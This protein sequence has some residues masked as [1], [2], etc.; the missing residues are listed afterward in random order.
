MTISPI[1][2]AL[3]SSRA[4]DALF[5]LTSRLLYVDAL[6]RRLVRFADVRLQAGLNGAPRLPQDGVRLG[7]EHRLMAL[8]VLH[9]VDRLVERRV[10]APRVARVIARL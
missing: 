2:P 3:L 6:R 1:I 8:A 7:R 9:T 4:G 5:A 10:L